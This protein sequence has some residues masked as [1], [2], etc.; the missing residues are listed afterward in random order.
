MS[1]AW[2]ALQSSQG[3]LLPWSHTLWPYF[4]VLR[5]KFNNPLCLP[6]MPSGCLLHINLRE[7]TYNESTT[8]W[9][10]AICWAVWL[11]QPGSCSKAYLSLNAPAS[12]L[13]DSKLW[14]HLHRTCCKWLKIKLLPCMIHPAICWLSELFGSRLHRACSLLLRPR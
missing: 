7:Q 2:S 4:S 13:E 10:K 3:L 6:F 14:Q 12:L 1:S 8:D 9:G 5:H 11:Q